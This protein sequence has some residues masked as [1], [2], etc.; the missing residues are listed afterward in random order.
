MSALAATPAL[1][2][3]GADRDPGSLKNTASMTLVTDSIAQRALETV[4][5]RRPDARIREAGYGYPAD[6]Y[7]PAFVKLFPTSKNPL[8]GNN[9]Y[10]TTAA[11]QTA[12][13]AYSNTSPEGIYSLID[14]SIQNDGTRADR[15]RVK[16]TGSTKSGERVTYSHGS[17]NLTAAIVAGTF[18]TPSL[19]A[20]ATYLIRAKVIGQPTR[21]ITSRSVS[22]TS[23]VDVVKFRFKL[24][25]PCGC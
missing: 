5:V 7:G 3:S 17:T 18:K 12:V 25:D 20:G 14:I 6:A 23:K 21:V 4:V 24:G 2:A 8:L 15:F 9:I 22:T 19:A 16:A 13:V 1:A 10:N 11:H